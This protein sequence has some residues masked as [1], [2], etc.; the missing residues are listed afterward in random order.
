MYNALPIHLSSDLLRVLSLRDVGCVILTR[1]ID[2]FFPTTDAVQQMGIQ[3][4][5]DAG[6]Q[7]KKTQSARV[8]PELCLSFF[9]TDC[10]LQLKGLVCCDQKSRL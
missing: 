3:G 2:H 7:T 10:L 5:A 1:T 9:Q 6:S 8:T 4:T